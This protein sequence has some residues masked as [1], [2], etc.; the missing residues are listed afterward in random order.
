MPFMDKLRLPTVLK[1]KKVKGVATYTM[2][3]MEAEVRCHSSLPMTKVWGFNGEFPG[4][5]IVADKGK[6]VRITQINNL[7]ETGVKKD[8]HPAIH[9]HGAHVDPSSDGHP[10]DGIAFDGGS[11]IYDY[12]NEQR[13]CTMWYHDHSHGLTGERVVKGLAGLYILQD[14]STEAKLKLPRGDRE[15]ALVIQDRSFDAQGQFKHELTDD[16]LQMGLPW[17]QHPGKRHRTAILR[18]RE[19]EIPL[20]HPQRLE[21]PHLHLALNNG[22]HLIQ[23]GTDGGLF[24]APYRSHPSRSLRPS[25]STSSSTSPGWMSAQSLILKNIYSDATTDSTNQIMRF[26][27]VKKVK[28]TKEL[29]ATLVQWE[30]IPEYNTD[31]TPPSSAPSISR[32]ADHRRQAAVDHQWQSL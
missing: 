30:E 24:S 31:G 22:Q 8:T 23:I 26:D 18:D 3:M 21:C 27:V 28:D 19:R 6:P 17:R 16:V 4:P 9:L 12:P 20:P 29:P 1:A 15:V 25:A 2:T 10:M 7:P 32:A 13:G 11:R 14:K 5:T